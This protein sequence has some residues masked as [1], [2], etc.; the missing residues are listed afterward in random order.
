MNYQDKNWATRPLYENQRE[1]DSIYRESKPPKPTIVDPVLP[2]I[3]SNWSEP[4]PLEKYCP[5]TGKGSRLNEILS[6]LPEANGAQF[7]HSPGMGGEAYILPVGTHVRSTYN[8]GVFSEGGA[9]VGGDVLP[10]EMARQPR[11]LVEKLPIKMFLNVQNDFSVPIQL[12]GAHSYVVGQGEDVAQSEASYRASAYFQAFTVGCR[13]AATW[14]VLKASRYSEATA[15][16]SLVDSLLSKV[17]SLLINGNGVT[18]P[19]GILSGSPQQHSGALTQQLLA[20][21]ELRILREN[22]NPAGL[23]WVMHPG[24]LEALRSTP[25]SV[26]AEPILSRS[27]EFLLGRPLHVSTHCP[28]NRIILCDWTAIAM[29]VFGSGLTILVNKYGA[30]WASGSVEMR[31]LIDCDFNVLRPELVLVGLPE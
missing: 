12:N 23:A 31:G 19:S 22:P 13:S 26:G 6:L 8:T 11:S 1:Y 30:G 3:R 9:L 29:S 5:L 20:A 4:K 24:V 27:H 17:D 16:Q 10:S 15:L 14:Q 2:R 25:V 21:M 18:E 7:R 28:D